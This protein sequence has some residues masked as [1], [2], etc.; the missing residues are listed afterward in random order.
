MIRVGNPSTDL[1]NAQTFHD[2]FAQEGIDFTLQ[3]PTF[4][5]RIQIGATANPTSE[6]I[7]LFIDD[8]SIS[9]EKN[10]P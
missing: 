7:E 3:E 6:N 9:I 10:V 2:L 5:E 1:P 4:Y 8:F